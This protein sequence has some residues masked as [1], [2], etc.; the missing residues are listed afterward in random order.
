MAKCVNKTYIIIYSVKNAVLETLECIQFRI[1]DCKV[2]IIVE[3]KG[4]KNDNLLC[5]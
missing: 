1:I 2:Q 3:I 4:S 5:S